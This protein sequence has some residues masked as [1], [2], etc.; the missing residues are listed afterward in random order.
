MME[1]GEGILRDGREPGPMLFFYTGGDDP[2]VIVAAL[3]LD[4]EHWA[5]VV[6][7]MVKQTNADEVALLTTAYVVENPQ[8]GVAPSEDARR[9][10]VLI[11]CRKVLATGVVEGRMLHFD[12]HGGDLETEGKVTWVA[13]GWSEKFDGAGWNSRFFEQI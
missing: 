7:A 9:Q 2:K 6:R 1:T 8:P 5:D 13:E 12:A 11:F 4:K 3:A 10:P